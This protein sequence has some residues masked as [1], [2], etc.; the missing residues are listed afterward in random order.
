[1]KD[2]LK[3][4]SGVIDDLGVYK[5]SVIGLSAIFFIFDI[6]QLLTSPNEI[7]AMVACICLGAS[8]LGHAGVL[9]IGALIYGLV[10]LVPAFLLTMGSVLDIYPRMGDSGDFKLAALA[11][12]LSAAV[13]PVGA[14]LIW[15]VLYIK[16]MF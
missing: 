7:L 9:N 10:Y 12:A 13:P 14:G 3:F 11:T 1:M 4:I 6:Y 8:I 15:V 16:R 2:F 5:A